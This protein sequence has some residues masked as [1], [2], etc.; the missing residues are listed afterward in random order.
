MATAYLTLAQ[1]KLRTLMPSSGV[2]ELEAIEAG[3]VD[4]QL[5]SKSAWINAR[6]AK[7]YATPFASASPPECVLDWLTR[8]V[9]WRSYLKRGVDP[10][11]QQVAEM[12]ADGKAA[13]AEVIEA[14]DGEKSHFEL[15]LR[16]DTGGEGITRAKPRWYSETSVYCAN[17]VALDHERE[18]RTDGPGR[19]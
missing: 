9:T 12:I 13:E 3:W 11:D 10:T 19:G 17:D 8:I 1:F 18:E 14:A 2:D 7:R 5:L 16:E 15:P 4:A 6:L